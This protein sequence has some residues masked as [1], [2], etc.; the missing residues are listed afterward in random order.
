[1]RSYGQY[2]ALAKAL[3]VVGERWT[4]L[5][6]RELLLGPRRYGQLQEGLPGIATNLLAERLRLLEENGIV[7]RDE[8]GRYEVT[9]WGAKLA[10]PVTELARWAAPLMREKASSEVFRSS[11]FALPVAMMFG[12]RDDARPPLVVEIRTDD[13]TVTMASED[14]EVHFYPGP[15]ASPDVMLSGPVDVVIGLLAGRM[16]EDAATEQGVRILGDFRKVSRLRQ[17][18]W[19]AGPAMPSSA[20]RR[21]SHRSTTRSGSRR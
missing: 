11:W 8:K 21:R 7:R 13:E 9:T 2:C 17:R 3:D 20:D 10:I 1:M 19:L 16:D 15:A 14:G 18:D 5:I 4:L 12:G 6:V